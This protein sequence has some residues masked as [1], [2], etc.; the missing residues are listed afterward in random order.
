MTSY[1]ELHARS[2]FSFLRGAANPEDFARAARYLGLDGVALCD[3]DGV[4]GAP[5]LHAKFRELEADARERGS[6]DGRA[7]VARVGAELTMDDGSVLPVLVA[8]R[9][10]YQN[11]CT[12]L[13]RAKLRGTKAESAVRWAELPEFAAGLLALTGDEEGAI[14]RAIAAEDFSGARA[15]AERLVGAFG[16][17]NVGV[18]LQRRLARGEDGRESALVDLAGALRLRPVATNGALYAVP[19]QR[20]VLDVLTCARRHTHL[21]AAGRGLERN[22]ERHLKSPAEMA[23]LFADRPEALEN[24]R[25]FADRLEF[26]LENLGYEFPRF[27][28]MTDAEMAARLREETYAG[29]RRKFSPVD[30]RVRDQ[31]ERELGLIGELGF[32]G[33]FLIVWDIVRFC[34]D[35]GI[36]VQGRGSA[37]NSLVCYCLG[38]TACDPLERK[39]LFERFL[40][41]PVEGQK[42][43]WPD[44]DLDLPSGERRESVIQEI[45][46]RYGEHGAAMTAN[47]ITFR[48]RS[49]MREIGKALNFPPEMLDRFSSLY[50][51]G[52]FPHT[53]GLPE[54]MAAAGLPVDHPRVAAAL[55]LYPR[56]YGLP[57]HL[58][59]H[60]GG[61]II[62]QDRLSAIVPLERASMPGRVVAQWDKDDCDDLGIIK[63][64]LLGLGMMA[65]MQD[66]FELGRDRHGDG[67][68]FYNLPEDQR[69]YDLLCEAD[70]IGLFQVESRAQMATL[71]RLK[72]R[73]FYDIAIQIAIIRPGPIQGGMVHPYI[74][75]RSGKEA[76]E[77]L[78][79]P[80]E[81]APPEMKDLLERTLGVPLFQEQLLALAIRMA[82]FRGREIADLKKALSFHRSH[83]RM[84]RICHKLRA[85]MAERGVEAELAGRIV[86]AVRS[87]A[88]Y[89]FPE[90]HA[91]SFAYIAYASA[92]MKVHRAPEFYAALLNNQPMGFYSPSTLVRD[93]RSRGVRVRPVSVARSEELC[94]IE[95]DDAL[96]LGLCVV[97]GMSREERARLVTERRRAEFVSV[98]DFKRRVR[99]SKDVAR[100][101]ARI[102]ALNDLSAD[103]REGLWQIEAPARTGDLFGDPVA[104]ERP[105]APMTPVERMNADY[106]GTGVTTGP[107]PMALVRAELPHVWRAGDLPAA[108]NGQR[109]CVAGMVICRQRPGTAK[110]FVFISLEDET[111]VA[112]AVV[113]PGLF[114]AWRLVITQ[115]PFLQIRGTVQ[116]VEGVIH[117]KAQRV[118]RLSVNATARLPESHDFH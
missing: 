77:Y 96:R 30:G 117:V 16:R 76:V 43:S 24:T 109:V 82:D 67:Y 38:I 89:G 45:Y 114:E 63:V 65:V 33:Y 99:P 44:I 91:L 42:P 90:S 94:T 71:P 75:R 36:L 116:N 60:S 111:G 3:R 57:R 97:R 52:D 25:R 20:E 107:H 6:F 55:R 98:E 13:T 68:D 4:Y 58:G 14:G 59:Q 17:E 28:G 54:Q 110:G 92:W 2:A 9:E 79:V 51:N 72:P 41:P 23:A 83:E 22:G 10:G 31:V 78:G 29:A 104:A 39:L 86:E 5:R 62:C 56:I 1:V 61:M 53:L 85:R 112:N 12:L 8:T 95:A 105:L 15:V 49:A 69:V 48:G 37:A 7:G 19:S 118:E 74:A 102:G 108:K 32:A 11:L 113:E 27:R 103:R 47:V 73:N 40:A 34:Q 100:T 80:P 46:R 26:S 70:T 87:F 88:V 115:E 21:D 64:D 66:A 84:D 106:A 18:E 93:A 50:A 81:Q 35:R 101:L